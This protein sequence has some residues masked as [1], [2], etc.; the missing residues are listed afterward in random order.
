MTIR[1]AVI[2]VAG[3]GT[4]MLPAAKA[5][6]KE[7]LPILDRPTVQYVVE[8]A[9]A[10]GAGEVVFITSREKPALEQHFSPNPALQ[11]R[12]RAGGRERLLE[13]IDRLVANVRFR[14]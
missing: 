5:V 4:R 11:A 3:F 8:E 6:P 10:A 9:A 13:S 2:P 7:L 14:F 12:L 1:K